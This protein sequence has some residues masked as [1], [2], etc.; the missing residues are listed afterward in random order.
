[1][2]VLLQEGV[3]NKQDRS[4]EHGLG[5]LLNPTDL[6]GDDRDWIGR[7]WQNMVRRA[8]GLPT[9]NLSFE[10]LP[11]VGRIT[12]S[13]PAVIHPISFLNEGR[14]YG[15]QIKPFNF[16]LTCQVKQLGH[17]TGTNP[18]RFH[19][20][21]RYELDSKRWLKKYWVDQYSG[22]RYPRSFTAD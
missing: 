18:E 15:D 20:I 8:I 4:S 11:A 7:A 22:I 19:L 3:S 6:H 12:I 10:R 1:M 5:H 2:P 17:P 13:S 16:L 21:G 14:A 9:E